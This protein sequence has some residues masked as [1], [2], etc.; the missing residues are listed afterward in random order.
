MAITLRLIFPK[1]MAAVTAALITIDD[2]K[3]NQHVILLF[4]CYVSDNDY[5][6]SGDD[7]D[8]GDGKNDVD[9]YR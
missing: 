4:R 5:N 7:A 1:A 9:D 8:V 3:V 6:G 2:K